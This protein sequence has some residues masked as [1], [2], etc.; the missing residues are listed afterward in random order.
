M[1]DYLTSFYIE[2]KFKPLYLT[3]HVGYIL[4]SGGKGGG[5]GGGLHGGVRVEESHYIP[6]PSG[7]RP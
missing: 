6:S 7:F 1:G 2:T 3:M 4:R 5:G